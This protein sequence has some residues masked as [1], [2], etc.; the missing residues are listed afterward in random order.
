MHLVNVS[1]SFSNTATIKGSPKELGSQINKSQAENALLITF[2]HLSQKE[3]DVLSNN[4][5][6]LTSSMLELLTQEQDK[7]TLRKLVEL[8]MPRK[9]PSP[10]QFKEAQRLVKAQ[11]ELLDSGDWLSAAN[12]A[13]LA[14]LSTRNPGSQPNKW[15]KQNQIFAIH[16]GGLD[17]F[18]IYGLNPDKNYRPLKELARIIDIFQG[19]K[20]E[21]Q[22]AFWFFSDNSFLGGKRPQDLLITSPEQVMAAARDE[23][24]G[25]QH[26]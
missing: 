25:I 15:K 19:I 9:P 18:P 22:M 2:E 5:S 1:R 21:W 4:I 12:I 6:Q 17:Y 7:G 23:A 24:E 20:N 26:G 11:Q 3:V 8:I 16:H 14:G 13:E 10:R